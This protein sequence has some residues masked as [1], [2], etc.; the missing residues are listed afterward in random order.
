MNKETLIKE[1]KYKAIRSSGAGGQHVNKVSSKVVLSFDV[2]NSK[3]LSTREKIRL[4]KN[5]ASRLTK[6]KILILSC[7]ESK[8]QTQNKARVIERFLE[9]ITAGLYVPK[10]RIASKPSKASIKRV[11]EGKRRR[12]ELKNSRKKPTLD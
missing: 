4:Y 11:K 8:S 6:E 9:V 5:L 10:R 1:L 7:E 2:S 12:G 3:G